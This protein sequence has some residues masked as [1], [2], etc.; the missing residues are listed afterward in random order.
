MSRTLVI[1]MFCTGKRTLSNLLIPCNYFH[2]APS[3]CMDHVGCWDRVFRVAH[4]VS[5][6][7]DSM[8]RRVLH[9]NHDPATGR[10]QCDCTESHLYQSSAS[11]LNYNILLGTTWFHLPILCLAIYHWQVES[12]HYEINRLRLYVVFQIMIYILQSQSMPPDPM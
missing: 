11:L 12:T 2:K 10:P 4:K 5:V 8:I 1:S 9:G 6:P 3:L 7:V